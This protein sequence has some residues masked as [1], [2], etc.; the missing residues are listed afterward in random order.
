MHI[1]KSLRGVGLVKKD[2]GFTLIEVLVV[3]VLIGIIASIAVPAFQNQIA[4]NRLNLTVREFADVFVKARGQAAGLHR[5]I[6]IKL[7][8]SSE[9]PADTPT[10]LHWVSKNDNIVLLS[11][12][13]DVMYTA[14]GLAK[15]RTK[16]VDNPD[17]DPTKESK[18]DANPPENPKQIEEIVP[19]E[20]ELCD[21]NLGQSGKIYISMTGTIDRI[22]KG[23]C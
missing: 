15:Q 16:M 6:T 12:K 1:N 18:P 2:K 19:L 9:C 13:I 7:A 8:C 21:A 3:V 22:E 14:V 11:D 20:F 10:T 17:H 4:K 5:D 23:T